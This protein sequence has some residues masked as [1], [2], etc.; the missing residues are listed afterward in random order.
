V[1]CVCV[2]PCGCAQIAHSTLYETQME[3]ESNKINVPRALRSS[4]LLLH[5]YMLIKKLVKMGDHL[6]AAR[7]LI[8]VSKSI[9]KFPSHVVQ[10]LTS[11]VIEC[12][13]AELRASA[14]EYASMLMRPE[15]R[16]KIDPKFKRK[17]EGIVRRPNRDPEEEELT[18]CPYTGKPIPVT[19]LVCPDTK[20]DIPF[21]VV[22]GQHMVLDDWYIITR[23]PTAPSLLLL[24]PTQLTMFQSILSCRCICP[25]SRMPALYSKYLKYLETEKTDPVCGKPIDEK[26]LEKVRLCIRKKTVLCV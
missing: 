26:M 20:N 14:Y 3:L 4:L 15:Y 25:N 17:I 23:S 21:C 9:S 10:I 8:R 6:G 24:V 13:R 1:P 5:S 19:E 16:P 11:T 12:L 7:M 18:P 22:S 2:S